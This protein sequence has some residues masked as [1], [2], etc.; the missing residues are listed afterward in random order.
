MELSQEQIRGLFEDF[1]EARD[2]WQLEITTALLYVVLQ[3]LGREEGL[4]PLQLTSGF[5]S[6]KHQAM[7]RGRWD[8]GMREGMTVR[9]ALKSQHSLGR[10]FDVDTSNPHLK[11]YGKWAKEIGGRW[12][13]DFRSA[14]PG[15]FDT[16]GA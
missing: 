9:P 11:H 15:H 6:E 1:N 4:V 13:G 5:R 16:K 3:F 10:A 7:L 14:D 2:N 8:A 12:G